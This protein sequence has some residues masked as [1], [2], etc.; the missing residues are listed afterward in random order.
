MGIL[1]IALALGG[2]A[3]IASVIHVIGHS[4][5]KASFFLTSGNIL[6]IF[7]SKKIKSVNGMLEV[8]SKTGWLWILSLVGI[9]ALPPSVLFISEFLTVKEMFAQ[10]KI[11]LSIVF[12]LLLMI[13][14]YG[15]AKAVIKMSF[16]DVVEEKQIELIENARKLNWT[17]YTPQFIML[18]I[19]FIL[20]VYM[21]EQVISLV[22]NTVVGL[23]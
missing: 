10:N 15:L 9:V 23:R 17:M 13:V 14:L 4:L 21:P 18:I 11:A 5:I 20:G 16:S 12:L 6:N 7:S 1:I 19:A 8:D 2:L 3:L 22:Q